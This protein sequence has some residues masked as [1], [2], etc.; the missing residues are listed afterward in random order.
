MATIKIIKLISFIIISMLFITSVYIWFDEIVGKHVGPAGVG[1]GVFILA[2]MLVSGIITLVILLKSPRLYTYVFSGIVAIVFLTLGV[3]QIIIMNDDRMIMIENTKNREADIIFDKVWSLLNAPT[4]A[5][6]LLKTITDNTRQIN[7]Q[8]TA[9]YLA[10][11][12]KEDIYKKPFVDA[13]SQDPESGCDV[14]NYLT[15]NYKVKT[16][17]EFLSLYKVFKKYGT[18]NNLYGCISREQEEN[19]T[20]ESLITKKYYTAAIATL[21]FQEIYILKDLIKAQKISDNK[22]R[23]QA[24]STIL[25]QDKTY[26]QPRNE[27]YTISNLSPIVL[28]LKEEKEFPAYLIILEQKLKQALDKSKVDTK[29][30]KYYNN[31]P[32]QEAF[33]TM[34]QFLGAEH[35]LIQL[36]PKQIS[37]FYQNQEQEILKHGKDNYILYRNFLSQMEGDLEH[38]HAYTYEPH[39]IYSNGA[40]VH[41]G[42]TNNYGYISYKAYG[43]KATDLI[44]IETYPTGKSQQKVGWLLLMAPWDTYSGMQDR[45]DAIDIHA[46]QGYTKEKAKKTKDLFDAY[47]DEKWCIKE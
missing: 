44:E 7:E 6:A 17:K 23:K 47:F 31:Q 36:I 14:V 10:L 35:S 8:K 24:I 21:E 41:E 22:Y 20:F 11:S 29:V 40:L 46:S 26:Y 27:T 5:E 1:I 13:I 42:V 43:A 32:T 18:I 12:L 30:W 9:I 38:V 33:I 3:K 2:I 39:R 19:F 4:K 15:E 25:N 16:E 34:Q 45:N 37:E 28:A